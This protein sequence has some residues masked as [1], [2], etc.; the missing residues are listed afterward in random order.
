[1]VTAFFDSHSD[2]GNALERLAHAGVPRDSIHLIPDTERDPS[3][4]D[5]ATSGRTEPHGF[6]ASL[7]DWLLPEEDRQTY[8]EGL[9][10]GGCLIAVNTG[11]D[12]YARFCRKF[13][14]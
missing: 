8:A 1:M 4:N 2:A 3:D 13:K 5:A 6:W 10:R 7:E 12:H 14:V 11:E 9:S